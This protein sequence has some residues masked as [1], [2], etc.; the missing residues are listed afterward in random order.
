MTNTDSES[1]RRRF[2]PSE[3][4]NL[5]Y[6][7]IMVVLSVAQIISSNNLIL[8]I[9][10]G[11]IGGLAIL[12]FIFSTINLNILELNKVRI[13][14]KRKKKALKQLIEYD[15]LHEVAK[16]IKKKL[17]KYITPLLG[18][19]ADFYCY[20]G[21]EIAHFLFDKEG[22]YLFSSNEAKKMY[23]FI[24]TKENIEYDGNHEIVV[25]IQNF[26]RNMSICHNKIDSLD[27][28]SDWNI[29]LEKLREDGWTDLTTYFQSMDGKEVIL[30]FCLV[31]DDIL[32]IYL[33]ITKNKEDF[34]AIW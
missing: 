16:Y 33:S 20:A 4:L 25:K 12:F 11:V 27:V 22:D 10:I 26:E 17:P 7:V 18:G 2:Q 3:M 8:Q 31:K 29:I 9:I 21:Y 30:N 6:L 14:K 28:K 15:K 13:Y 32:F 24:F 34:A 5:I 23:L 1:E 19:A